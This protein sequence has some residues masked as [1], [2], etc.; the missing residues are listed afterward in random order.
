MCVIYTSIGGIEA[1]VCVVIAVIGYSASPDGLFAAFD[2]LVADQKT[3]PESAF[4]ISFAGT[5]LIG[6][7][8]GGV[9][10]SIYSYVGSQDIVQRYNITKT[11]KEAQN[12]LFMN[13][14]L[15]FTSMAIFI[16]RHFL[17][18]LMVTQF[19]LISLL[20]MFQLV[21]Q[22]LSLLQSLL[23]RNQRFLQA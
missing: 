6:I 18:K 19:C 3:L 16:E 5:T 22:V 1:V 12:S 23:L 17:A 7:I 15:L 10:N 4:N 9:I 8:L 20:S 14:P 21:Y 13:V 2:R 11:T